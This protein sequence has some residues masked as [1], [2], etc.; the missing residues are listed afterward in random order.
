[1][2][3]SLEGV[4]AHPTQ[5]G[6]IN[7]MSVT[8][9]QDTSNEGGRKPISGHCAPPPPPPSSPCKVS[10]LLRESVRPLRCPWHRHACD[11]GWG[12]GGRSRE[13]KL[14]LLHQKWKRRASLITNSRG[15]SLQIPFWPPHPTRPSGL[16]ILL[17][18]PASPPPPPW[19]LYPR[20]YATF[21]RQRSV[22][23]V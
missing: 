17:N 10:V 8:F 22:A 21:T 16:V 20:P 13:E 23:F 15:F 14:D 11:L 5:P 9:S 19:P 12:G 2:S 1:M 3:E 18:L 6:S 7:L 4:L